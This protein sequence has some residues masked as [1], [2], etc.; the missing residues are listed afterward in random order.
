M[1]WKERKKRVKDVSV[2]WD[3]AD[4]SCDGD[5]GAADSL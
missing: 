5:A 4:G 3:L 1:N 2:L